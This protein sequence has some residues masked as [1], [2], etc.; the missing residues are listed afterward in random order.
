MAEAAKTVEKE[1]KCLVDREGK[2][3]TFSLGQ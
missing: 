2:Y 3:L 1:V